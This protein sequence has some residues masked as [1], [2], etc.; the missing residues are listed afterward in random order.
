M[1]ANQEK[2]RR[3]DKKKMIKAIFLNGTSPEN[4]LN[5]EMIMAKNGTEL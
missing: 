3:E 1:E 5:E 4:E 2:K